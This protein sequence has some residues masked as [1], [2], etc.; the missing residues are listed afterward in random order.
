MAIVRAGHIGPGPYIRK[1]QIDDTV[2]KGQYVVAIDGAGSNH[3]AIGDPGGVSTLKDMLGVTT[4]AGT[5]ST[6]IGSAA[7]EVEIEV[8]FTGPIFRAPLSGATTIGT[9]L[10]E[11]VNDTADTNALT[12]T[13]DQTGWTADYLNAYGAIYCRTGANA[14]QIRKL[15]DGTTTTF[16]V[17]QPFDNTIAVGDTFV[18]LSTGLPGSI[19]RIKLTTDFL[20]CDCTANTDVSSLGDEILVWGYE[21][22]ETSGNETVLFSLVSAVEQLALS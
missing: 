15:S 10:T 1:F 5:V 21:G 6:T 7:V 14:G 20:A 17:V 16:V 22:L 18:I 13:H 2:V 8:N 3:G 12:V 11:F 4:E 19:G 9:A